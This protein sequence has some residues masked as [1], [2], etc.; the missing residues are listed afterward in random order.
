M[1]LASAFPIGYLV[2]VT[3]LPKVRGS[4]TVGGRT[5]LSLAP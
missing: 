4:D 3:L 5:S 1:D 2:W